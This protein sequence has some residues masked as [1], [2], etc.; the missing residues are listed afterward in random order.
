MASSCLNLAKS[1]LEK[2]AISAFDKLNQRNRFCSSLMGFPVWKCNGRIVCC[3][4]KGQVRTANGQSSPA[5]AD[6]NLIFSKSNEDFHML[7]LVSSKGANGS[8][9]LIGFE[10]GIGIA[11]FLRGK[12][13]FITGATGFLAKVLIE[14]ILRTAP[15]VGKIYVLVKA[16]SKEAALDRLKSE[17]IH[18]NTYQEFMLRKLVPV[19]GDVREA[20]MGIESALAEEISEEVHVIV[21]SAASTTF[22]ERYDVAMNINTIGPFRLMSFAK[23]FKRLKLFLQVSTAYVNGRRQGRVMER[24][25]CMGDTISKELA[26][27][28]FS[29]DSMPILDIETEIR[30]A[31]S[32]TKAFDDSLLVK[33][34]KDLGLQRMMDPIVLYYGKGQLTG[35]PAD[36]K[37]VI[38]VIPAD[39]V[40][41]ATL[42]AMAK[43]GWA[44]EPGINTYHIASSTV[45]PLV[46]QKLCRLLYKYFNSS[47]FMDSEGRPIEV[48]QMKLFDDI[49]KFYTHVESN[50]MQ[51]MSSNEKRSQQLNK[52]CTMLVEQAKHLANLYEPYTF[53]SGRF[54]NTNTQRLIVEMSEEEKREFSF[55]VGGIDWEDYITNIHIPGLRRHVMKGRGMCG[56]GSQLVSTQL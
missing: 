48:P 22:D 23:R 1:F 9:T 40:V 29:A 14:K 30:L 46:I 26:S 8:T 12:T 43:H 42:A 41:N 7:D 27:P 11:S 3:H 55:D 45:N 15:D 33:Q 54:D 20:N 24:S 32:S 28:D 31:F 56:S 38:D 19:T 4:A 18:G 47:P 51:Q 21:N 39:M 10:A 13:F 36:P 6:D 5:V 17:E 50:V 34:M 2:P 49:N 16:K 25:F 37:G 52:I 44:M 35:F 53:Y